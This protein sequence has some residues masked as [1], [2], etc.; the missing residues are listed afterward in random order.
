M[1]V[2][3][4]PLG[5]AADFLGTPLLF[6]LLG[7]LVFA[8]MVLAL[9]VNPGFTFGRVSANPVMANQSATAGQ[10]GSADEHPKKSNFVANPLVDGEKFLSPV[11][12]RSAITGATVIFQQRESRLGG[13][14][15]QGS[16]GLGEIS[17]EKKNAL[18]RGTK[19]W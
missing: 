2:T 19:N 7:V 8:C 13:A 1:A 4:Y 15:T 18:M 12:L 3:V 10:S 11:R 14:S 6:G 5:L 16:Y 17:R 9:I